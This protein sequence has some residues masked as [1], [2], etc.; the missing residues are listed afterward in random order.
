MMAVGCGH[1]TAP[2]LGLQ[3]V[4]A[5]QPADLLMIDDVALMPKLGV[6]APISIGLEL[7]ADRL[8]AANNPG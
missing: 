2:A 3:V 4:L 6:D 7:V 1:V 8:Q 5:H